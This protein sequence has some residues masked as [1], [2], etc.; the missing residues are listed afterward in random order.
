MAPTSPSATSDSRV[1]SSSEVVHESARR[2]IVIPDVD[3][4]NTTDDPP[5]TDAHWVVVNDGGGDS[6]ARHAGSARLGSRSPRAA[7][8]KGR[9]HLACAP[10]C[11]SRAWDARALLQRAQTAGRTGL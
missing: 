6:P 7:V 1:S 9:S 10:R 2:I 4:S 8:I 3:A 5:E 11:A